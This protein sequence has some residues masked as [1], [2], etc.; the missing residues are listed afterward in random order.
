MLKFL[1]CKYCI[2]DREISIHRYCTYEQ[3]IINSKHEREHIL[4]KKKIANLKKKNKNCIQNTS[5]NK[6]WR[7]IFSWKYWVVFGYT[8]IMQAKPSRW[9][10]QNAYSKGQRWRVWRKQASKDTTHLT[11]HRR[12]MIPLRIPKACGGSNPC[13]EN[14]KRYK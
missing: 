14:R 7:L 1:S 6:N 4:K 3:E 8:D 10:V 13:L 9:S 11:L 2:C 12:V 5:E